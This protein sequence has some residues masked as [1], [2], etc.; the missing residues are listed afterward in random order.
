MH[1]CIFPI[2]F[3][4]GRWSHD[5]RM[6]SFDHAHDAIP[7]VSSVLNDGTLVE[8]LYD[9]MAR[10]TALAVRQPDGAT[11]VQATLTLATGE[12]LVPYSPRNGLIASRTVLLPSD[13]G[14]F[15]DKRDLAEAV[16][17][18]IHRY[19][20]L[21]PAFEEIATYYVLLTWVYDAFGE[22]PYLRFRG[23]WGTGKTRAL[24]TV[25]S[26]CYKPFFASGA[27][28]TSPI[29][30]ILDTFGGTLVLDEADL[31]F[32]DSTAELTKI[33]NNGTVAGLPVLRTMTTRARE[34]DPRAFHVFGPK[35]LGM[36]EQF[37]DRALESRF[38][39]EETGQRPL[40]SDISI[41]LPAERH[42]EAL[43]LR[44]QLLAWRFHARHEVKA[45]P[46]KLIAGIAPRLNQTASSLL[47]L[48][49]DVQVQA[50]VADMLVSEDA[51]L[52][53]ERAS[54]AEFTV[55]SAL[56]ALTDRT[57]N[58]PIPLGDIADLLSRKILG[59]AEDSFSR[60]AVGYVVRVKLRLP[61]VKSS[62]VFVVP[63][64]ARPAIDA[65]ATRYG[66][67]RERYAPET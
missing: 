23:D 55:L 49:D 41:S 32:S 7:T 36:R 22:L 12:R 21:S 43:A 58:R 19:V 57:P 65:L 59:S 44:N 24:L 25:G 33:L 15:R 31:R 10:T 18:F 42:A 26:L 66:I 14:D 28:T 16:R 3:A 46:S 40:R 54:S 27:S 38:L 5:S 13:I 8:L 50:R 47:S 29:F 64:L 52:G 34:L 37:A 62:G 20:D 17:A 30:H 39:T 2:L 4:R 45:D 6:A 48:I 60:K 53:G 67:T 11:S 63:A 1:V 61:T 56:V 9:H 51:R 35:L